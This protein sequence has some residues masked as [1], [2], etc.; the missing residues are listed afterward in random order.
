VRRVVVAAFLAWLVMPAAQAA[1]CEGLAVP[2]FTQAVNNQGVVGVVE[3]TTVAS[4]PLPWGGSIS[5]VTRIWGGITAERWIVTSRRM[6][7]CPADPAQPIGTH[8][9]DFR[10]ADAVW[11]GTFSSLW[12][13]T[14]VPEGDVLVLRHLFG[15]E[16]TFAIG[17]GDRMM[18]WIRVAGTEAAVSMGLL[19]A[20]AV[21]LVRR[22][23]RK[24]RDRH[25][26]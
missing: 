12:Y 4:N 3:R 2:E 13:Q 26:F 18:A 24:R 9:L 6:E 14:S 11:D 10:G 22:R 15:R 20:A 16:Q 7:P 1:A 21:W 5:V 8:Q 23:I 25:L 17:Q 19:V